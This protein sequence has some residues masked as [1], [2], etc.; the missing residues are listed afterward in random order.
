MM[1]AVLG[2]PPSALPG[3]SPTRGESGAP[4]AARFSKSFQIIAWLAGWLHSPPVWGRC[5]AVTE[6]SNPLHQPSEELVSC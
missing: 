1:S 3:I 6:G 2:I 5:H 4:L